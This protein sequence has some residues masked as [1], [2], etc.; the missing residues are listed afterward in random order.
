MS[1]TNKTVTIELSQYIGT[2]K[3]TYLTD[4]NGDMLKIDSAIAADRDS[5]ASAQNT[6]DTAEY[7]ADTNKTSIDSI[8]TQLNGDPEVP[9]DTGLAGDV[10]AVEGQVN[11]INSLLGN[12]SPTTSEQTV[13]GAINSIEASVA[14]R[15]DNATFANSYSN[16]DQFARGG[17]VYTALTSISAGTAF[18]SLTLNTDYKISDTLV[19]QIANAAGSVVLPEGYYLKKINQRVTGTGDGVKTYAKLMKETAAA[20]LA[21]AQG[22]AADEYLVVTGT[23][24][25]SGVLEPSS[26]YVYTN[27]STGINLDSCKLKVNPSELLLDS[28]TWHDSI[29]SQNNSR[30]GSFINS[31]LTVTDYSSNTVASGSTIYINYDIY[32]PFVTT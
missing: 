22:L 10:T 6:A 23:K 28:E 14:P 31:A 19:V 21:I 16:G 29:E 15:E 11:T 1:S 5:I 13:I 20:L 18:A 7:K 24:S 32:S 4:Y 30:H 8:N 12:G 3:P 25:Y 9:S 17:S 2:D 27:A 26:G